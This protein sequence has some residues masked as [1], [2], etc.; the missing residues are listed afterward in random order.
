MTNEEIDQ[1]VED[2]D[3]LELKQQELTDCQQQLRRT[4]A[5]VEFLGGALSN[6]IE[7]YHAL[8]VAHGDVNAANGFTQIQ[9]HVEGVNT[10]LQQIAKADISG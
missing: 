3:Q 5:Q 6:M 9:Q 8:R 10:Q 7:R 2:H 1:I 4:Q